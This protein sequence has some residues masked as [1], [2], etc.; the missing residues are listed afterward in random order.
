MKKLTETL[1]IML[2]ALAHADAG[3]YLNRREKARV[4]DRTHD[5]MVQ[6]D[7]LMEEPS[8]SARRVALHLGAEL[9][10]EVMTYVVQTCARLQHELTVLTFQSESTAR[11]LLGPHQADLEAAGIDMKLVTLTGDVIPG[12]ASYLR[13]HP[14]IAF[15]ACRDS[16]HLGS[17]YLHGTRGSKSLPVPVVVVATGK[18]AV[19]QPTAKEQK[20]SAGIA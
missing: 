14:E 2:D 9:P 16:G 12:L 10:P 8:S 18:D 4:L 7:A 19:M 1:K 11:A 20:D 5:A 6:A 15:L 3:E 13:K 17:S